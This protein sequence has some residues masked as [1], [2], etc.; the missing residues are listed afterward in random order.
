MIGIQIDLVKIYLNTE[1]RGGEFIKDPEKSYRAFIDWYSDREK[2]KWKSPEEIKTAVQETAQQQREENLRLKLA[3]FESDKIDFINMFKV[4]S[5]LAQ[6]KQIFI[7]KYDNAVYNTKHFL[8][9]GDGVL[10][11]TN[12]EGYVAVSNAGDA[13]PIKLVNRLDFS[14]ANFVT[15]KPGS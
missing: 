10:N 11:V 9:G 1:V 7:N 4:S 6:A 5:L 12:P 2:K 13:G 15:G 8:D 14:S 3:E